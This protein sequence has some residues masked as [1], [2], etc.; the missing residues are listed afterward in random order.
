LA[1]A[2]RRDLPGDVYLVTD[3]TDYTVRELYEAIARDSGAGR[4]PSASPCLRPGCWPASGTRGAGSRAGRSPSTRV[5]WRSSRAIC[6]SLRSES[7]GMPGSRRRTGC[8]GHRR[9]RP[10]VPERGRGRAKTLMV[11]NL[12]ALAILLSV[13][14]FR[15]PPP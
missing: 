5:R 1:V 2:R 10:M 15:P 12:P 9:D 14:A 3:G 8:R 11:M 6:A 13:L 4:C 7:A